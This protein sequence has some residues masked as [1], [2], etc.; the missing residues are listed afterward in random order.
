MI[1]KEEL[2][3]MKVWCGLITVQH[4]ETATNFDK[5]G[6]PNA[7]AQTVLFVEATPDGARHV[8]DF[9]IT[10]KTNMNRLFE[11]VDQLRGALKGAVLKPIVVSE[12]VA[13]TEIMHK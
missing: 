13:H 3:E 11:E 12:K 4:A 6:I 10:V 5:V 2:D 7:G 1:T 8:T 9:A